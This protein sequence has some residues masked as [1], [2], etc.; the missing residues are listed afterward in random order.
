MSWELADNLSRNLPQTRY[1]AQF[2]S[3]ADIPALR[4]YLLQFNGF[5]RDEI[6]RVARYLKLFSAYQSYDF[7]ERSPCQGTIAHLT[8][9][10]RAELKSNVRRMFRELKLRSVRLSFGTLRMNVS[11]HGCAD[12]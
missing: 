8:R 10:Q 11:K 2:R 9:I 4:K 3:Q 6:K 12:I 7:F 1:G 5:D